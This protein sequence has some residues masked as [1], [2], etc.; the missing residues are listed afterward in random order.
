MDEKI[1][2]K[3]MLFT[4]KHFNESCHNHGKPVYFHSIKVA[5]RLLELGYDEKLII[6]GILHDLVE[7]TDCTLED[8]KQEFGEEMSNL[9]AAVSFNPE[10]EDKFEQ[11]KQMINAALDY[12]R[13][14]I[15]IKCIDMYENG[16]YFH[17]VTKLDV[18]EYLVKKYHYFLDVAQDVISNEPALNLYK[19]IISNIKLT[20]EEIKNI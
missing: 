5:M 11:S 18:K 14:A 12:G 3:A 7:D 16:K 8:I 4:A 19:S 2:N 20:D 9:V 17:L 13:D 6:G 1:I 15:I 10:I